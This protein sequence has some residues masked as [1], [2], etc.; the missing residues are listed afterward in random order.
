MSSSVSSRVGHDY[1]D[2]IGELPFELAIH[3]LVYL[4]GP[5][6][7]VCS[8]VSRGWKGAT[9]DDSLW[10]RRCDLVWRRKTISPSPFAPLLE[11][12]GD[13]LRDKDPAQRGAALLST[14]ADFSGCLSSLTTKEMR[15]LLQRRKV[16]MTA[17]VEKDEFTSAVVSSTPSLSPR[18]AIPSKWKASYAAEKIDSRRVAITW[19][20]ITSHPW[21]AHFF[22]SDFFGEQPHPVLIGSFNKD[23]LWKSNMGDHPWHFH[24]QNAVQVGQF[25]PLTARRD[26]QWGWYLTNE[27]VRLD[28]V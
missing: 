22:N 4:N 9:E 8:R 3:I 27:H 12:G 23:Y 15:S 11:G 25:P 6:L 5:E 18:L 7:C 26:K 24:D 13:H 28:P 2:F 16:N 19:E 20:E 1:L 21:R 14:R 17:F 10:R